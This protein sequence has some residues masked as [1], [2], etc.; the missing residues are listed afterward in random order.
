MEGT[1]DEARQRELAGLTTRANLAMAVAMGGVL[2]LFGG[3]LCGL[4]A[5]GAVAFGGAGAAI[6]FAAMSGA[7][8]LNVPAPGMAKAAVGVGLGSAV[9]ALVLLAVF[10]LFWVRAGQGE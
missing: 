2:F 8:R 3:V 4:L 6:G 7:K 9:L 1:Q 5:P 10:L